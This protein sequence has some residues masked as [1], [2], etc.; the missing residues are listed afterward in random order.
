MQ[1]YRKMHTFFLIMEVI[2]WR[3]GCLLASKDVGTLRENLNKQAELVLTGRNAHARSCESMYRLS[4]S[5]IDVSVLESLG[6][7]ASI[8]NGF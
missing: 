8:W 1:S 3:Q 6:I 4:I 5:E 2:R 7:A